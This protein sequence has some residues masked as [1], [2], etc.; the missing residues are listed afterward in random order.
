[1]TEEFGTWLARLLASRGMTQKQLAELTGVTGAAVNG[2]VNGRSVPRYE[3]IAAI[4]TALGV[5]IEDAVSRRIPASA[6]NELEWIFRLAPDDGGREG[7]NAANFAF[8]ASLD[9]LAREA[10]QNSLDEQLPGEA[11]VVAR[12][13]LHELTG[14]H[15]QDF[16]DA[17]GWA[18]IE[19]HISSAADAQQKVGRVLRDGLQ[20]L[21]R[22]QRLVLLRV[23]DHNATG[24]TG[25]EYADGRF[26]RVVRRTL[27]S[28][29]AGTQG[30][31]YG[32]GKAALWAASRFGLV[33]VNS[34]LSEPEGG[35]SERR[36][37]GRLELPWHSL[38]GKEYAGP[39]WFGVPDHE[40]QNTARS[41]WGTK[42]MAERLHLERVDSS[43]GTSFLVVGAYDGSG[44]SEDIEELHDRLVQSLSRN[45]WASMVGGRREGAKLRVA[46]SAFRN[47]IAV[48]PENFIDPHKH[49]PA[50]SRA[51]QAF[52]DGE[53]VTEL[54]DRTQVLEAS[55]PLELRRRKNDPATGD[56]GVHEAVL[57][58][59]PAGDEDA[60]PD[61][62]A[63]MRATRMVVR[64]KRVGDLPL[65]H[66][67]FQAVLLAGS[68]TMKSTPDA[69]AAEQMLRTAEPP[70]HNDW[71]GTEDLTA[72][73][74]R[75]ARQR[76]VDFKR[77]AE[78]KVR[79]LLRGAEEQ[80]DQDEGPAVL[81]ELLRLDPPK[82]GRAQGFPTVKAI[83]GEVDGAGAWDVEV[84]VQLPKQDEPW[85]LTPV[86]RFVARSTGPVS[87]DWSE[88]I[89]VDSCSL[90]PRGNLVF[91]EGATRGRFR[92]IT[93]V[94]SHP[95]SANMAQVMVEIR[96]A[97]EE[98]G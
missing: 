43:P 91:R 11:P 1:M 76:I 27:D 39:G 49:E 30:G 40:R 37:A 61:Q 20:E 89:P 65:G 35:R 57:L 3:K 83:S 4:A 23:D 29:K 97:K 38:D 96:R 10:T 34:T 81:R 16:M 62:I 74:E 70:D 95:V 69:E 19:K 15:L 51:V 26:S 21:E 93:A 28:G 94:A 92:G 84:T 8:S 90:T 56:P 58:L 14:H 12:Y 9:V 22:T 86:P 55:V 32:L 31:S 44:E 66:R 46:V 87:V 71:V 36:M 50:R 88:V 13:V 63:F 98:Q 59:T 47:G 60:G 41:W 78:Q 7:G 85:V 18:S 73:Y 6:P 67:P 75:G 64:S 77:A 68:A 24:L 5:E 45:F 48:R 2:W 53:T 54:T 79:E 17:L 82:E 33:L 72:T 52:L 25:P 80:T 42:E